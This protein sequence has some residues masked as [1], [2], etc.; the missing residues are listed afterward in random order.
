MSFLQALLPVLLSVGMALTFD[1]LSESR[2]LLA[3]NFRFDPQASAAQRQRALVRR[4]GS[5]VLLALLFWLG[6]FAPLGMIGQVDPAAPIDISTPDLFSLHIIFV[7]GLNSLG[8]FD[9]M[10]RAT[11]VS[12]A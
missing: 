7:F 4:T 11:S 3:P 2:G 10:H 6:V 12:S 9:S 1:R 5:L 8:V